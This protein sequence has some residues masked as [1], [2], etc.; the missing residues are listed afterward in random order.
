MNDPHGMFL[1]EIADAPH[2]DAPRLIY[3]DW[4]E[5]RGDSRA[6]FIRLAV[7][8]T[9][10]KAPCLRELAEA[11]GCIWWKS[12]AKTI[13]VASLP[14]TLWASFAMDCAER[15]LPIW[16]NRFPNDDRPHVFLC[17]ARGSIGS[18]KLRAAETRLVNLVREIHAPRRGDSLLY[19]SSKA[20]R[21]TSY[22]ASARVAKKSRVARTAAADAAKHANASAI[23]IGWPSERAWQ[24]V[25]LGE[26]MLWSQ[27]VG[28]WPGQPTPRIAPRHE[29]V[30]SPTSV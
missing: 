16:R 28:L 25:R 11:A 29:L 7:D 14:R 17:T 24:L 9:R 19:A 30:P 2:D 3:A 5:E 18:D 8:A 21:A 13:R 10:A 22:A 6:D 23:R 1:A 20:A 27:A 26:Y 4:L 15:V 12:A